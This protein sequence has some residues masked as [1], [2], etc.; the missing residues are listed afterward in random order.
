M[1]RG[2]LGLRT[3]LLI[4]EYLL[5]VGEAH[6]WEVWKAIC[7]KVEQIAQQK[8]KK[9]RLPTPQSVASILRV[10]EKLGLVKL[11]RVE[12]SSKKAYYKR[13]IYK[14]VKSVAWEWED[15]ITAYYYPDRFWKTR[16]TTE[17]L[18]KLKASKILESLKAKHMQKL[19]EGYE[20]LLKT[21]WKPRGKA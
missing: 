14:I 8:G 20:R 2:W 12:A 10:C 15:P 11:V 5:E 4:R 6:P 13:K 16:H 9:Y 7:K 18:T 17:P 1:P 21:G 3:S 19:R